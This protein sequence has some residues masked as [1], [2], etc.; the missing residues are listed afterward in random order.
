MNDSD[1]TNRDG[2]SRRSTLA[3]A[4]SVA[5][6]GVALIERRGIYG[7]SRRRAA[8]VEMVRVADVVITGQAYSKVAAV[9]EA[10]KAIDRALAQKKGAT[11]AIQGGKPL[12]VWH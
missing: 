1:T 10:E 3:L 7:R 6:L 4:T 11:C 9:V 12:A 2:M 8:L 5:A